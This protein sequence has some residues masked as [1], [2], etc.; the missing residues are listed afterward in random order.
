MRVK[1]ID[2]AWGQL[3]S[4]GQIDAS[5]ALLKG[6]LEHPGIPQEVTDALVEER[7]LELDGDFGDPALG[8][9]TEVDL[10]TLE[11][12]EKVIHI[13]VFNRGIGLLLGGD[14]RG[15]HPHR[16]LFILRRRLTSD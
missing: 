16:F 15:V 14:D 1:S 4:L 12:S 10:L 13:R 11:M 7:I 8:E 9:P 2:Y 5:K 6:R 3:E